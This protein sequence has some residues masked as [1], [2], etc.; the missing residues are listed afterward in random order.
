MRRI[1]LPLALSL[2]IAACPGLAAD[3]PLRPEQLRQAMGL[4]LGAWHST[5]TVTD[6]EVEP[7]PGADPA[8]ARRAG[9]AL[10]PKIGE[11][12]PTEECLWDS[13]E[14][15]FIPGLRVGSG[16]DFSRVEAKGGRFAVAG[17]CSR[18]NIGVRLE[19]AIEGSYTP[20]TMTSRF[21]M[22]TTTGEMRIRMK[23]NAVSRFV[24]ACPPPPV[25]VTPD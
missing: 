20:E 1:R 21:D 14:L 6:L 7:T 23:A 18:P 3:A 15:V 8:E 13:P 17:S 9:A 4:K 10:R 22:T 19:M 25:V 5:V 16:C 24:G 2:A 12:R 11:T